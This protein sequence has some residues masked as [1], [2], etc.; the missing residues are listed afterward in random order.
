MATK[1][2]LITGANSG[3]GRLT[4]EAFADAGWRTFATMRNV[5]A[6]NADAA[7]ELRGRHVDVIEL[8]V[9]S[10]ASVEA[11][12]ATV[13]DVCAGIDVLVNN[14][15]VASFGIQEAFTPEAVGR[16]YAA[17]V[18]GPLRVNRAFLPAM[19]E[20]RSGLIVYISSVVG[21]IVNP[22]GGVYA[23]SKWALE[24]LAE[25]SSY[26]LAPLGIDV[27]IVEP[28][29]FLTEILGKV[30]HPDDEARMLAYGS[31]LRDLADTATARIAERA[32]GNDPADI[33]K[34]ILELATL[35]DGERPLRSVVPPNGPVEAI[36]AAHAPI[37]HALVASLGVPELLP[38]SPQP[39][40]PNRVAPS[41]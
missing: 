18:F 25:A 38:R 36:N 35:G 32:K 34:K 4:A 15:G 19:R 33:A 13:A 26:E 7:A 37:Q 10:D 14:A 22:F 23:S 41:P 28:G 8:D 17:N 30:G 3:F 16:V 31:S 11:A 24:A 39:L 29:A 1:N 21:R 40:P 12:A 9:T 20:R 6:S 5:A 27:A 2:I